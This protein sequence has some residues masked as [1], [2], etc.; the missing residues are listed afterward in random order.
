[1]ARRI[2]EI[3]KPKSSVSIDPLSVFLTSHATKLAEGIT[4]I[5]NSIRSGGPWP[6]TWKEEE[7]T[8][9]PKCGRPDSLDQTRN[10]SCTSVFSKVCEGFLLD[11]LLEETLLNATQFGGRKGAGTDHM[12]AEMVTDQLECL[13]DNRVA[14]TLISIDMSKAFNRMDH[15]HA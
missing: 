11:L 10:I 9:I 7:G 4:L 3:K 8:I 12:L 13:D 6:R 14:T 15:Q 1:M 5:I 2:K